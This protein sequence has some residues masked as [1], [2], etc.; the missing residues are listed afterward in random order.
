MS[1]RKNRWESCLKFATRVHEAFLIIYSFR[2]IRKIKSV[3]HAPRNMF[4]FTIEP[5]IL[6]LSSGFGALVSQIER[7]YKDSIPRKPNQFLDV[8]TLGPAETH[9]TAWAFRQE[10]KSMH[11]TTLYR[12]QRY[13]WVRPSLSRSCPFWSCIAFSFLSEW[14]T[15]Q[16]C[17]CWARV[18]YI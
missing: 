17:F 7:I 6:L 10:G 16:M 12:L 14:P 8:L 9:L 1:F 4:L 13:F 15:S 11:H 3:V 18:Q 5:R 2:E